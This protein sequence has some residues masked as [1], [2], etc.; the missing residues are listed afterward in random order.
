MKLV[1]PLLL[2]FAAAAPPPPVT[3]IRLPQLAHAERAR[4]LMGTVCTGIAESRADSAAAGA[5]L[6]AAFDEIARL[7]DVCSSWQPASEL[8]RL[9]AAAADQRFECSP[10]LYAVIDSAFDAAEQTNGAFDP[11]VEPLEWAWDMRGSG[12]V[13]GDSALAEARSRVSWR[14]VARVPASRMVRFTHAGMGL[15]LGGIAKGYA[16]DRAEEVLRARGISRAL[17]DFGGQ[18]LAFS[19]R[20]PWRVSVAHPADRLQ[21]AVRLALSNA[22]VSTS[23]QSERQIEVDGVRYGHILDPHTGRPLRTDASATVVAASGTRA[24]ALSTALLVMGR[25]RAL[26]FARAH[27]ELGV[28]WLEPGPEG[29]KA[30]SSNLP[31]AAA[32]PG[33]AVQWMSRP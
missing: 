21:P 24:D 18:L 23:S 7:E 20:E 8:Q 27:P 30:W 5:A 6:D 25:E 19:N 28:L 2:L 4:Y 10:D 12:R 11:T 33:A 31:T 13:P 1:L 14:A 16:L 26:E 3:R 9:N 32:A 29:V 17:L 22:A 15:D